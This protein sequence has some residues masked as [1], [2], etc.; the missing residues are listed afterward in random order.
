MTKHPD[1]M[2]NLSRQQQLQTSRDGIIQG[3]FQFNNNN[4]RESILLNHYF[5]EPDS[6]EFV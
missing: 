3:N 6:S 4:F 2:T 5:T 1:F